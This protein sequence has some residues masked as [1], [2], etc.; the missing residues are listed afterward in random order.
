MTTTSDLGHL[1][2]QTSQ[3]GLKM[4]RRGWISAT[5]ISL[6]AGLA[7]AEARFAVDGRW[8]GTL[9]GHGQRR[10]DSTEK[11]GPFGEFDVTFKPGGVCHLKEW[12]LA[13]L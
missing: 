5:M 11:T 10:Y 8:Q 6:A 7:I 1:E 4:I 3:R 13:V 12:L 9:P 2:E